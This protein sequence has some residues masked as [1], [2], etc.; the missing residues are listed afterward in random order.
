MSAAQRDDRTK[1]ELLEALK[2]SEANLFSLQ[3]EIEEQKG[4]TKKAQEELSTTTEALLKR[5]EAVEKKTADT[6]P[7]KVGY[8]EDVEMVKMVWPHVL[9]EPNTKRKVFGFDC[10]VDENGVIICD[11]P[12]VK[13]KNEMLRAKK[14][15]S[16]EKWKLIQSTESD[17]E[18]LE[19]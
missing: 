18:E 10:I 13:V 1:A 15:I 6:L 9:D 14:L 19:Q 12:R 3:A 2:N 16:L 7:E 11:V 17:L 5:L 4:A 8:P